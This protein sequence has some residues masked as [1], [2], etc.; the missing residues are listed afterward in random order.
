M[1]ASIE[2]FKVSLLGLRIQAQKL[3]DFA[4]GIYLIYI[5]LMSLL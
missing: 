4:K 2:T 1:N 5:Y 3:S